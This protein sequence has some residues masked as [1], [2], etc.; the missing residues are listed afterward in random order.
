MSNAYEH[1][2]NSLL[3]YGAMQYFSNLDENIDR[4]T[5]LF[6]KNWY[7]IEG[8]DLTAQ[9]FA[10]IINSI[11]KLAGDLEKKDEILWQGLLSFMRQNLGVWEQET[12]KVLSE[13][14]IEDLAHYID[15]LSQ[16]NIPAF[17]P[18]MREWQSAFAQRLS[19][20][21][22]ITDPQ[23]KKHFLQNF[24]RGLKQF[25]ELSRKHPKRC[26]AEDVLLNDALNFARTHIK[27]FGPHGVLNIIRS[28]ENLSVYPPQDFQNAFFERTTELLADM[29]DLT[30]EDDEMTHASHEFFRAD[31]P[32]KI[33]RAT[34]SLG[35]VLPEEFAETLLRQ[36]AVKASN[37]KTQCMSFWACAVHHAL[38]GHKKFE[39][40]AK[41][42]YENISTETLN[43]TAKRQMVQASL[44]FG[45]PPNVKLPDEDHKHSKEEKILEDHLN[46]AGLLTDDEPHMLNK[47][48]HVFDLAVTGTKTWSGKHI[49]KP[50]I[51]VEYD[52]PQH[53]VRIFN[54]DKIDERCMRFNG[55]TLFQTALIGKYAKGQRVIRVSFGMLN[56]LNRE[57]KR[58]RK[59]LLKRL[60]R[61]AWG[62]EKHT[63]PMIGYGKL[64]DIKSVMLLPFKL[65][66]GK[67]A[68][69]FDETLNF[70]VPPNPSSPP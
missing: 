8:L 57:K 58:N 30:A 24:H 54:H 9:E 34:A 59:P 19:D 41:Y 67:G 51:L 48:G 7:A 69:G 32:N 15:A 13:A 44:W 55:K 42:Y 17:R 3:K 27:E 37:E 60:L 11:R 50:T 6:T 14:S 63:G 20:F 25:S 31:M 70:G 5:T 68:L 43:T 53:F 64:G 45:W 22:T 65:H 40:H 29:L 18:F 39:N 16:M 56:E 35:M 10:I 61:D 66:E 36:A 47:L 26:R 52:G 28:F 1:D 46:E 33:L 23:E 4:G 62:N 2:E 38:S 49:K 21:E 12:K